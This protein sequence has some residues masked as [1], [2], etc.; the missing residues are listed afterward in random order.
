M[1]NVPLW[2]VD[3]LGEEDYFLCS[4]FA[5]GQFGSN[6]DYGLVREERECQD[7]VD[8]SN[9]RNV[10]SID[11]W[12][13]S[14][15][16]SSLSLGPMVSTTKR[17]TRAVK[18][19]PALAVVERSFLDEQ[20]VECA[21]AR[22]NSRAG[23]KGHGRPSKKELSALNEGVMK[24]THAPTLGHMLAAGEMQEEPFTESRML[25]IIARVKSLS[26]PKDTYLGQGVG[27]Y[28][29]KGAAARLFAPPLL[30]AP[31][32][33]PANDAQ[34]MPVLRSHGNLW[35][36]ILDIGTGRRASRESACSLPSS[37]TSS[38][39]P[40]ANQGNHMFA[41]R[42]TV[43]TPLSTESFSS[44]LVAPS[45]H[46]LYGMRSARID[47]VVNSTDT[48]PEVEGPAPPPVFV[49]AQ[50]ADGS[51][52]A[53]SDRRMG[54]V[55]EGE[56]AELPGPEWVACC[57][58]KFS[59]FSS[60]SS[61][62]QPSVSPL[63]LAS[64]PHP[65]I[66]SPAMLSTCSSP[67]SSPL[68][69]YSAR[70]GNGVGGSRKFESRS[71]SVMSSASGPPCGMS[72]PV[73]PITISSASNGN[74]AGFALSP[75]SMMGGTGE[76]GPVITGHFYLPFA[77]R[78]VAL[79]DAPSPVLPSSRS[80]QSALFLRRM[81]SP[82]M[83]HGGFM[84]EVKRPRA[85]SLLTSCPSSPNT[86]TSSGNCLD[87]LEGEDAEPASKRID[88]E[89]PGTVAP[90]LYSCSSSLTILATKSCVLDTGATRIV[91]GR[92]A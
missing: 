77:K 56:V 61:S 19:L 2:C 53:C 62:F 3:D 20:F 5:T 76:T 28:S 7:E 84:A 80:S 87:A 38:P 69:S 21:H 9:F 16:S 43:S 29:I 4:D 13:I 45:A 34:V 79:F 37:V 25:Q 78:Q 35:K 31:P 72:A 59:H 58:P 83:S 23:K 65:A 10:F 41:A 18:K 63:A 55:V 57:S 15:S 71:V 74:L 82:G 70:V 91:I 47:K 85:C 42:V 88:V 50:S 22:P 17:A 33:P 39:L 68:S 86:G 48:A 36:S 54:F 73:D 26:V 32:A 66:A 89:G 44:M 12:E 75:Y 30:P 14:N 8:G 67:L 46:P 92:L 6:F 11:E 24:P 51:R 90:S 40:P 64:S 49:P 81:S 1:S 52:A 60:S 27:D